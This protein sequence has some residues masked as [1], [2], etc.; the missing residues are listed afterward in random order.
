[1][2]VDTILGDLIERERKH[3]VS[4]PIVQ[5]GFVNLTIYQPGRVRAKSVGR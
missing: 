1:V 4:A 2:E 5:A 3:G